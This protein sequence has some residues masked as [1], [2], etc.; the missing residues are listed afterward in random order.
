MKMVLLFFSLMTGILL[1][2]R[3]PVNIWLIVPGILLF[4]PGF[5]LNKLRADSGV[6][7]LSLLLFLTGYLTIQEKI[8]NE[9]PVNHVT[10][11]LDSGPSSIKGRIVSFPQHYDGRSKVIVSCLSFRQEDSLE[12]DM[13]GRL[14]LT[15][16]GQPEKD[17][18]IGDVI[19]FS[20]FLKPIRNFQN[21][22]GF[23]Y[24]KFM[25]LKNIHGSAWVRSDRVSVVEKENSS[26]IFSELV[27]RAAKK[28]DKIRTLFFDHVLETSGNSYGGKVLASVVTGK[29]E[30]ISDNL[31]DIFSKT[32]TSHLLAISGLHLSIVYILFYAVFNWLFSFSIS[33]SAGGKARKAAAVLSLVPVM[34]YALL[35]GFS[36]SCQRAMIMITVLVFSYIREKEKDIFSS[37]SFAGILILLIDPGALFSISFQLSF[38]AV[39]F[40]AAGMAFVYEKQRKNK[41]LLFIGSRTIFS[42]VILV[43]TVTI[44]AGLGTSPLT[45]HY[46]NILSFLS[47]VSN[48]IAIPVLGFLVLPLGLFSLG[49]FIFLPETGQSVFT[50]A[51]KF[52]NFLADYLISFLNMLSNIPFSWSR[53]VTIHWSDLILI[54]AFFS[55]LFLFFKGY[56]KAVIPFVLAGLIIS[57]LDLFEPEDLKK[58]ASSSRNH[59]QIIVMDV[60]QG[61][62]T[63]IRTPEKLHILVDGGGFSG[64][65]EFDPGRSIVAPFLWNIGIR[66]ID[67]VIVSHPESDHMNG[68]VFILEN[69]NV[70][71]LIKNR[72]VKD[73]FAYKRMM[74]LCAEKQIRILQPDK[75]GE[76]IHAG[77]TALKFY[78]EFE[79]AGKK[80]FNNNSLVFK[81]SYRHFSMLFPGDILKQREK[82]LTLSQEFIPDCDI[83]LSP[84]HGSSS[85]S[86]KK[87]LD[88]VNPS[89]VIISCGWN[90]RY[91]F[92]AQKVLSRYKSMGLDIFRTDLYGAVI[93]SSDGNSY[94]VKTVS[95]SLN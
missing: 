31:R 48:L 72:D 70:H 74:D 68:L 16:Y 39:I 54:Y 55:A 81:I 85:S 8:K 64:K 90:N 63:L 93:V 32:G 86:T 14:L 80:R 19:R 27:F 82:E 59:L 53:T 25:R 73:T 79:E 6:F 58:L 38:A 22:G 52:C 76:T 57:A 26:A 13:T 18:F 47:P 36:P 12:K 94:T 41:R 60:G 20:S 3:F 10:A 46:F 35:T 2:N 95:E 44:L 37:I 61:S 65:S 24:I 15:I 88:K 67:Y 21:P 92:P 71:T 30:V 9:F 69:F 87:F 11:F 83:L 45:A 84:H 50:L 7:I 43:F 23:D 5:S 49:L 4:L 66:R 40:I 29:K 28:I 1:G 77:G 33:F 56:K 91:G 62:S 51:I 42:R 89:S 34:L 75:K 78:K 17:I